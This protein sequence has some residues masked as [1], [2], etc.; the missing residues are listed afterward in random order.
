MSFD[1]VELGSTNI[2]IL[3]GDR[4]KN[5]PK[6]S[7][8][9]EKGFCLFLSAK[10]VT[11]GGFVFNDLQFVNEERDHLLGKGR[12]NRYD[13]ILTTRGT[14]G[15]VAYY[16]DNIFFEKMR[17]NSG[18][19]ILRV[20]K[21]WSSKFIYYLFTSN[22][23]TEQIK[24]LTSG[25]AVPQ[26]P[27]K[28]IKK[29]K[30]PIISLLQQQ[31]LVEV[32]DSIVNKIEINNQINETLEAMAQAIFKSWFVDFDPVRAKAEAKAAGKDDTGILRAAMAVI[33]SK[34][35]QALTQ[36]AQDSPDEYKKLEATAKAFPDAF[37]ESELGLIPEGWEVKPLSEIIDFNPPRTLKKGTKAPYV[38]MTD[39]P[40]RGHRIN[41][42]IYRDMTSGAKFKNGDT[43]FARITPCLENGKTA[44]V[45]VLKD[46][47]IGWGS[48]EFIVMRPKPNIP[49]S[50]GYLI[51][52]LE[53]FR[54]IAVQSMVGTSG[55]QRADRKALE[56][57][58]WIIASSSLYISF[59]NIVEDY[60]KIMQKKS[61][62]NKTLTE[63]RDSLLP[64]LLSGEIEV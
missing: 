45:D 30:I 49:K 9:F 52:R 48:T 50:I 43:L 51:V 20:S 46:D 23:I 13:I 38:G 22:Y 41:N 16:G 64:K 1:A 60:M 29:L 15:N 59:G 25:S 7:D 31:K 61:E 14:L 57:T 3:D 33:S 42:Y 54:K 58:L 17:I 24:S 12:L 35:E 47:E 10:N 36:M 26:L 6:Q 62:E 63:L 8:F 4:G 21:E 27:I 55:R 44:Y 37:V 39:V 18:M 19:V 40:E 28:D 32:L 11:K 56:Q 53:S 5:Y 34:S 2:Q